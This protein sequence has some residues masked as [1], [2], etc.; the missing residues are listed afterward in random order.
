VDMHIALSDLIVAGARASIEK[1]RAFTGGRRPAQIELYLDRVRILPSIPGSFV[2]R[3]LLPLSTD[4]DNPLPMIGPAQP[5]V[6][7]IATTMMEASKAAV[8]VAE[9]FAN[10][11]VDL[12]AWDN[13][14][15]FGVSA[16][17]CDALSRL[18]GYGEETFPSNCELSVDWTW[19]TPSQPDISGVLISA[20][21]AST[22]ALGGQYLQTSTEESSIWIT[23]LVTRLHRE[24]ALG[25]GQI[26]VKGYV[27]GLDSGQRSLKVELDEGTYHE[28]IA[29]HDN[30]HTVN[31]GATVRRNARSL[32]VV[33]V[34]SFQV[35]LTE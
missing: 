7:L 23:G 29:A 24:S 4:L 5:T 18:C 26:T 21:L 32:E 35:A 3:A 9:Q 11:D 16:N 13:A 15:E 25:P 2:A 6:R 30:G 31:I 12:A 34:N 17:L 14:V 1:R 19:S 8:S 10:G 33:R 28:A 27:E 22:L 20:G